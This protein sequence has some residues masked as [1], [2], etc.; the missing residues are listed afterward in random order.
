MPK[1]RGLLALVLYMTSGQAM[2]AQPEAITVWNERLY[3][4]LKTQHLIDAD[5]QLLEMNYVCTLRVGEQPWIIIKTFERTHNPGEESPK[6][7]SQIVILDQRLKPIHQLAR[8]PD[9]DPIFCIGNKLY[10]IGDPFDAYNGDTPGNT[11]EFMADHTMHVSMTNPNALP[12]PL[13][14]KRKTFGAQ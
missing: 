3:S 14:V 1:V 12:I 4:A 9:A 8:L 10:F 2:A 11:V 6:G 13:T 7:V 5:R